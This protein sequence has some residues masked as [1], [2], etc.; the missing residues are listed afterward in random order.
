MDEPRTRQGVEKNVK[1]YSVSECRWQGKTK[2]ANRLLKSVVVSGSRATKLA[3]LTGNREA[4][5]V[6]DLTGFEDSD[7][8][9]LELVD[10]GVDNAQAGG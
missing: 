3:F 5:R 8:S 7:S 4:E 10:A 6:P 9:C 1:Q 2:G